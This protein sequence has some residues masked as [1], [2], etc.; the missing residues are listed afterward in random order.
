MSSGVGVGRSAGE[1]RGGRDG[2]L[3]RWYV[4]DVVGRVG[5]GCFRAVVATHVSEYCMSN[6]K[7]RDARGTTRVI[8]CFV[9]AHWL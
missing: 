8:S 9:P 1:M 7:S 5:W 2:K 3:G 4:G 6:L